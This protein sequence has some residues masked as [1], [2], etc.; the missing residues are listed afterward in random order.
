MSGLTV[1]QAGKVVG[2]K[3]STIYLHVPGGAAAL[4]AEDEIDLPDDD[5]DKPN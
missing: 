5:S 2:L 1:Q 3:P 4:K